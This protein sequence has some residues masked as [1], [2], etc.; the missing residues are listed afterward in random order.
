MKKEKDILIRIDS[1]TKE[2]ITEKA[3]SVYAKA[4]K[5]F[6]N[7]EDLKSDELKLYFNLGYNALAN[8]KDIV[9]EI[10]SNLDDK[11]KYDEL[12]QK[13]KEMYKGALPFFERPME[14]CHLMEILKKCLFCVMKH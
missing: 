2:K 14:L 9:D 12:M 10:N 1:V 11:E 4:R 7:D 13:R 8:D 6:P 5:L 3:K